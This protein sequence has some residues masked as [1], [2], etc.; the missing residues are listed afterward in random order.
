MELKDTIEMMNS[1]DYKERFISEYFQVRIRYEA[2]KQMIEDYNVGKLPFK[3]TCNI[4]ALQKQA[5]QMFAYL[6]T[7]EFRAEIENINLRMEEK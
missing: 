1:D 3:P 4:A 2:L 5:T 6:R 7:L